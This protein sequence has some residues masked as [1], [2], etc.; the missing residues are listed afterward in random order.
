M[1]GDGRRE[2]QLRAPAY[3][4]LKDLAKVL[5]RDVVVHDEVSLSD[6]SARPDFAVDTPSGRVGYIE[7]KA[8]E[9]GIPSKHW[10]PTKHD[11]EQLEKLSALPNLIY[12]NG[13]YWGL[14][15]RGSLNGDVAVLER[16]RCRLCD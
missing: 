8:P 15:R 6:V 12:T 10:R 9:K 16:V 3:G 5:G 13:Q 14:Y 4:L 7:L 11:R 1:L 2:D